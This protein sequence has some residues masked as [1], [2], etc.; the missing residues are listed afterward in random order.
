MNLAFEYIKYWWNAKKRHGTHS[1]FVY[2]FVDNCLAIK[3]NT[4]FKKE[5]HNLSTLLK[6]DKTIITIEDFGAGSKKLSN[7]R[8]ISEVFKTSSSKGKYGELLYRIS[9]HYKPKRILEFGTSLGIGT[10][11]MSNGNSDSSIITVEACP[12]TRNCALKNFS[13]FK[14]TS[15]ESIQNTFDSFLKCYA[16]DPFDLVFIDGHHDGEA[17]IEYIIRLTPFTHNDTIFVLDD[18]R[19]SNSMY[20][21]WKKI[22]ESENFHVTM[23]LFRMGIIIPRFQQEKEH[24]VLFS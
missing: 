23:D 8:T 1:P 7:Q 12:A 19:W 9:S 17:L 24:F 14:S 3:M 4:D 16:G 20:N 5:M 22:V 10:L 15:I 6:S 2:D 21:S 13:K 18:I 11:F